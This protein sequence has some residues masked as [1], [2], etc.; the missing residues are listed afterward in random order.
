MDDPRTV[1]AFFAF[2]V[3]LVGGWLAYETHRLNKMKVRLQYF[4]L[5]QRWADECSDVISEGIMLCRL[6]PVRTEGPSF[7]N[8]RHALVVQL[9]SLIDRGRWFFPNVN[10]DQRGGNRPGAF[11]GFRPDVLNALVTANDIIYSID[12][13][14]DQN[15]IERRS[16]LV[17][18]KK[19]F[20]DEIQ[21]IVDPERME[22][23]FLKLT[24]RNN[25]NS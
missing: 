25:V 24:K 14:E 9:S 19:K 18:A 2:V 17:D 15:N 21:Q 3:S 6:D 16:P 11:Q 7:F 10:R 13:L 12:F 8:R 5:L 1:I 20:V 4:A 23:E 22:E